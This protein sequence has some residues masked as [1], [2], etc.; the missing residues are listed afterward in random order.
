MRSKK[1]ELERKESTMIQSFRDIKVYQRSYDVM[2]E[3]YRKVQEFPKDELY[4]LTSQIKRASTSIPLNIAEGYGKRENLN[5]FRRFLLMA[6]GSCDEMKVLLD[7]S[8]DLGFIDEQFHKTKEHEYDEIG[9][10]L[11]GLRDKWQ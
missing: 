4:G 5:E 7:I 9:R 2:I 6:I 8:K 3:L 11:R 1:Q 10:M